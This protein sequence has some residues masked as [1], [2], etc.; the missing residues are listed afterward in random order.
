[1]ADFVVEH[2]RRPAVGFRSSGRAVSLAAKRG[3]SAK[4]PGLDAGP[5]EMF[6]GSWGYWTAHG[7]GTEGYVLLPGR[8]VIQGHD[9][10]R[11]ERGGCDIKY[12]TIWTSMSYSTRWKY[13]VDLYGNLTNH[14]P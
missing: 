6:D 5:V 2:A 11:W 4:S 3:L 7:H 12:P 8:R 13:Q 14:L 9:W 1:M 10:A